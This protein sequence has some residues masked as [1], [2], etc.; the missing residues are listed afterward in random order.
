[1]TPNDFVL[2]SKPPSKDITDE[3]I[4]KGPQLKEQTIVERHFAFIKHPTVSGP[5]GEKP[6]RIETSTYDVRTIWC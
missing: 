6:K 1:M 2:I 5:L 4:L 3:Y